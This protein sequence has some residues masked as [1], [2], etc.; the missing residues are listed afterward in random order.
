MPNVQLAHSGCFSV[1][2]ELR[3]HIYTP[4]HFSAVK[5]CLKSCYHYKRFNAR[6]IKTNQSSYR[7]FRPD[8]PKIPFESVFIDHLGPITV[9]KNNQNEKAL[10]CGK[11][12]HRLVSDV[13]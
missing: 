10:I 12:A 5:K 3:K 6:T 4:K 2:A 1:L 8:P 13:S 9:K 11:C 7:E